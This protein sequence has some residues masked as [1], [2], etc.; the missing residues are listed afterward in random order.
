MLTL[1]SILGWTA[2]AS[3][4]TVDEWDG[5]NQPAIMRLMIG[6]ILGVM[7]LP[8]MFATM[9]PKRFFPDAAVYLGLPLGAIIAISSFDG[10]D[11]DRLFFFGVVPLVYVYSLMGTLIARERWIVWPG[12]ICFHCGYDLR[13]ATIDT[14][15]ECG[16]SR[17]P[18]PVS[19]PR[20][21]VWRKRLMWWV[22]GAAA[23]AA[24]QIPFILWLHALG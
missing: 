18:E 6:A 4:M 21:L 12:N 1:A 13:A 5:S 24:T 7:A 22:A 15:S 23:S 11:N 2:L 8:M 10:G 16:G 3:I 14:C 20:R 9:W 19:R 17:P